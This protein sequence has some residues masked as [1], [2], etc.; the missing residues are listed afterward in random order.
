MAMTDEDDHPVSPDKW[1]NMSINELFIQK[2]ILI[3]RYYS[4]GNNVE[5]AKVIADGINK[6]NTLIEKLTYNN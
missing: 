4:L 5:Y 6:I 3:D 1:E 2:T